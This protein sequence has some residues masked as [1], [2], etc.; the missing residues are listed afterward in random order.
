MKVDSWHF[1]PNGTKASHSLLRD[2]SN[3]EISTRATQPCCNLY[4]S[5]VFLDFFLGKVLPLPT[6]KM[7]KYMYCEKHAGA[8]QEPP[9][10]E[11]MQRSQHV[12]TIRNIG[13]TPQQI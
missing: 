12:S 7:C 1:I 4:F 5:I 11:L 10:D 3:L 13:A 6:K 2:L 8:A 9:A